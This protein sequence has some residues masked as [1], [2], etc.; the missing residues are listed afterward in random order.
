MNHLDSSNTPALSF[1]NGSVA[2]LGDVDIDI[3]LGVRLFQIFSGRDIDL[4]GFL[5]Q[6][7]RHRLCARGSIDL[8]CVTAPETPG[9]QDQQSVIRHMIVVTVGQETVGDAARFDMQPRHLLH[10]SAAAVEKDP[11]RPNVHQ[12]RRATAQRVRIGC[13]SSEKAN[14]HDNFLLPY[15]WLEPNLVRKCYYSP[16]CTS[17]VCRRLNTAPSNPTSTGA[18]FRYAIT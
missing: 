8:Q 12:D 3:R 2:H 6:D 14:F 10:A 17:L 15:C 18:P 4:V 13:A 16:A 1:R 5:K 7:V 9:G 11:R